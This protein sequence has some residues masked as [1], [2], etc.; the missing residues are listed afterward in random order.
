MFHKLRVWKTNYVSEGYVSIF[1]QDFYCLTQQ[2]S[3]LV[4][5][6]CAVFQIFSGSEKFYGYKRVDIKIF[7]IVF[8]SHSEEKVHFVGESFSVSLIL[9]IEKVY[10]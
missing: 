6:F 8:L 1:C 10:G 9:G 7:R 4:V 3:F 5:P 2:K